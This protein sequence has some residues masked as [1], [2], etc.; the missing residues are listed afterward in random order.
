MEE[1]GMD[2]QMGAAI[3]NKAAYHAKNEIFIS[4]LIKKI[5]LFQKCDI[6]RSGKGICQ[7]M[8]NIQKERGYLEIF[9][10]GCLWGSIGIFVNL[11]SGLGINSG[12]AAFIRIFS[13]AVLLI[14]VMML[15]GGLQ[16]MRIDR[17]GLLICTILGVFSQ[18]LFNF[19]YNMSINDVGM[20]TASVLLYTSPIFVCM[21]SAVF[22]REHIGAAKAA[23]LAVNIAGCVL[24]VTGGNFSE[25]TFSALGVMAG[26]GAGFFY[27]LMT[28]ISMPI[29]GRYDP[30]TILFYSFLSGSAVLAVMVRPWE[31][32]GDI[33]G[34][35]PVFAASAA[36]GAIP[37]VGAYMLYM[38][39]LS[40][41]PATSK[42]P[43]IASVETVVAALIGILVFTEDVTLYKLIGILCV[44]ISIFI[45][46]MQGTAEHSH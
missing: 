39:G 33:S 14:P 44:M 36:Y 24:T 34:L 32:I 29:T 20:A 43:V 12:T 11:L 22:F 38:R 25:L 18:A 2:W 30:L 3:L 9:M 23:A 42:V 45:M 4:F 6:I 13:G 31:T 1:D 37:T 15:R 5:V 35:L 27:G 17:K 16:L 7:I 28:I 46:N 40:K 21:M 19:S 10:A 8:T 26:V 41:K